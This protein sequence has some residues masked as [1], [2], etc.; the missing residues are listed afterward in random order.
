MS[1]GPGGRRAIHP[2]VMR[3]DDEEVL[4]LRLKTCL[5]TILELRENLDMPDNASFS[6]FLAGELGSLEEFL[7][8]LPGIS[9][10]EYE[11]RRVELATA[12][13]LEGLNPFLLKGTTVK[14]K[15]VDRVQ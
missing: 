9:V 5:Q 3:M 1:S 8:I 10:S 13:F 2:L 11:V 15:T 4:R 7:D 6:V 12:E 14:A